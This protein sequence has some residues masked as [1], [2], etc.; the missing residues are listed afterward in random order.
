MTGFALSEAYLAYPYRQ[1]ENV[2]RF[3]THTHFCFLVGT[4]TVT[5][6]GTHGEKSVAHTT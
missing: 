2:T 5:Y 6:R 3:L 1:K 4:G